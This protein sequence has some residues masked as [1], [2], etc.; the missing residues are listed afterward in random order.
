MSHKPPPAAPSETLRLAIRGSGQSIYRLAKDTNLAYST[1]WHFLAGQ[2]L[3]SLDNF[4][5]LC[6]HL[7][8]TLTK[9]GKRPCEA[10]GPPP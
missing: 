9:K 6:E 3:L 5:R 1:L 10:T 2:R 4:D 8:L 7:E